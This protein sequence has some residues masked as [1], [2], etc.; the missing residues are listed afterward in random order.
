ME[1]LRDRAARANF[2]ESLFRERCSS[3]ASL[4]VMPKTARFIF[5]LALL[6]GGA[7][8]APAQ[9]RVWQDTLV[10]PTYDEGPPDPN[11]AFD[12]LTT[13]RFNYPYTLRTNLT[14]RRTDHKW[15]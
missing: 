13:S 10:L 14:N 1:D 11:P 6:A 8:F 7:T 15:R 9:V 4:R 2:E 3:T 5:A 12:Q